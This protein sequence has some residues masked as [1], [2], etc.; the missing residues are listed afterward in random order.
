MLDYTY[1][2]IAAQTVTEK[3]AADILRQELCSRGFSPSDNHKKTIVFVEDKNFS[4]KDSFKIDLAESSLT[5]SAYGIRGLVYGIGRFLRKTEYKNSVI[6]LVEDISGDYSPYMKIRGHQLGYRVTANTYEAWTPEQYYDYIKELMYF[7]CNTFEHTICHESD[8]SNRL[9]KYSQTDMVRLVNEKAK[10]LDMDISFWCPNDDKSL[11]DTARIRADFFK[12]QPYG[13]IYFPP[14][15]D[16][17][18]FPAGE[19]VD[20][21]THITREIR[22][23][24]PDMQLWPSA[25]SPDG[26]GKWGDDFIEKMNELPDEIDGI[27][28]GPNCA[29]PLHELR[30]RLPMKYPI[31]LYPDITHN[32]RCEY[33]VHFDRD[34]WHYALA[35]TLSRE[36]V[37]PRPCEYR[38]IHRLTRQYIVGS[39]SYS[40]GINDDVNKFVWSDMD[41]DPDVQLNDTLAD[42]ARL[43]FPGADTKK[44]VNG[45]LGL[46]KNWE[47]DPWENPHIETTYRL[48]AD[49]LDEN[50]ELIDNVRFLMCLF[51]SECD[52]LVKMRRTTENELVKK[53]VYYLKKYDTESAENVL[54]TPFD[55]DYDR[56]RD[57]IFRIGKMLFEKAGMQL[58]V[59][60]YCALGWERG[61]TLDTIDN[62]VSD[63]LWLLD[64]LEYCRKLDENEREGFITALLER[65]I[66]RKGEF[67]FSFAEHGFTQLGVAQEP[68]FYMDFQGDRPNVNNGTIP[69]SM[70]KVFDHYSFRMKTGGLDAD[71]DYELMLNIKP[72]YRDEV[73]DFTVKINGNILYQGKQ[74]GGVRDEK[75]ERELSATGFE[76]HK[77]PIPR[78]FIE[79]GCIELEIDEP[80]IGIMLSEVFIK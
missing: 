53:A 12:N 36:A 76:M 37:N 47:G 7:G 51:R 8:E 39:V 79:N 18:D 9:M 13:D 52:L 20:R 59:E 15:S 24:R 50:P 17:G 33:P 73:T 56:L 60:N 38:A 41:F 64:R 34:D 54:K 23:F 77:Y 40:E 69:M 26:F 74:Y 68:Y 6:R 46:E 16:P 11:E 63:R 49:V 71:R 27:I 35:A 43:F 55:A 44:L 28:T 2:A 31:R 4:Q 65:N 57:D 67:Y 80:K 75:W 66:T 22:K 29:M 62:P 58:D 45:I 5:I 1:Y 78:E 48:F 14:G 70:L 30:K 21:V 42:Y 72:R 25:Q 32:V 61:A 19:L 10:T 3:Q